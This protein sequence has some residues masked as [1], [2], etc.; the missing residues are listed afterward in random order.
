LFADT[1]L[2]LE[3]A[4]LLRLAL[5]G[6]TSIL[7]GSAMLAVLSV[8]R[9]QSP[10]LFHFAVQTAVWGAAIAGWAAIGWH[11]L[12]IRDLAAATR[13]DRL[14]WLSTGLDVG[15]V[16]VG[17]TLALAGWRLARRPGAIGAG[18]GIIVQGIA[19]MVLDAGFAALLRGLV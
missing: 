3:R 12:A 19:L 11:R 13:L 5:W 10:L 6:A 15:A 14:L 17:A 8:R 16:A 1:L 2:Q 7:A 9:V 18:V 4:H